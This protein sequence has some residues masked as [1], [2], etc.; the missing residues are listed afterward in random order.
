MAS[1][2]L[3]S[4]KTVVGGAAGVIV[5]SERIAASSIT[6]E[7]ESPARSSKVEWANQWWN[8]NNAAPASSHP[9]D[10][11]R[12]WRSSRGVV[13]ASSALEEQAIIGQASESI[14]PTNSALRGPVPTHSACVDKSQTVFY[15]GRIIIG[16]RWYH[17]AIIFC[18][19]FTEKMN[20]C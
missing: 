6:S 9:E 11:A 7:D 3:V 18:L 10:W 12:K 20:G 14:T 4:R 15:P 2:C 5:Y 17:D 13:I 19:Y 16:G 1:I 8:I